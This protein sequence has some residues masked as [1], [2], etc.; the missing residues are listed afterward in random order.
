MTVWGARVP[1]LVKHL[2]PDFSSVHDP[3]GPGTGPP[4]G[5]SAY[6]GI[7]LKDSLPLFLP[8]LTHTPLSF[9]FK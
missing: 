8:Q 6:Q 1:Q 9:S 3:M 2:A 4:V 7:C 5:E